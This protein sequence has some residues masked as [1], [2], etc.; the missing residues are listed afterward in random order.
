MTNPAEVDPLVEAV[1]SPD[2]TYSLPNA[3]DVIGPYRLIRRIADGGMSVVYLAERI[4]GHFRKTAGPQ[5]YL[6]NQ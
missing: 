6:R 2:C 4:D 1:D 3:G 5:K